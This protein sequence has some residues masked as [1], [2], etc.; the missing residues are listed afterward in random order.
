MFT[1]TR[2][3][4]G[5]ILNRDRSC[6][7]LEN[8]WLLLRSAGSENTQTAETVKTEQHSEAKRE[9]E[10]EVRRKRRRKEGF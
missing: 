7:R 10:E 9:V 3:C 8:S 5:G 2:A 1:C 6:S 4:A